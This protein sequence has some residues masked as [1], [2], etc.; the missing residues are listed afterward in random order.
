MWVSWKAEYAVAVASDAAGSLRADSKD[1]WI[2]AQRGSLRGGT[3]APRREA[4]MRKPCSPAITL[5]LALT[6]LATTAQATVYNANPGNYLAFI[7]LLQPG[8]TLSLAAGSYTGGLT[9]NDL[10]GAPG[11]PIVI[12]GPPAPPRAVFQA[13]SCCNTVSISDS[14]YVDIHNLELNGRNL[15]VDAVKAEG[16]SQWAHH[17]TLE[18]LLIRNHAANQQIVGINTKCPAWN[19]VIRNNVI[20]TAGTGIYLG[21]SDGSDEFVAGLIEGNLIADTTGYNLQIK[22][23]LVR[24]TAI[25]EPVVGHTIIRHNVFIKA[26]KAST[27]A[28]ARPNVLVGHWPLSGVGSTDVYMIYGNAFVQNPTGQGLFQGEGNVAL[29]NNVFFNNGNKQHNGIFIQPQNDVPKD[30]VVFGNTVVVKGTGISITGGAPAH[31]QQVIGNAVFAANPIV[32]PDQ[33][34][35]VTATL[36]SASSYLVS[37][38]APLGAGKNLYPRVGTLDGPPLD[39]TPFLAFDDYDRDFNWVTRAF[40]FRGG[41][42]GEGTNPGWPLQRAR[43]PLP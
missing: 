40:L 33:S 27:G 14:S 16:T 34:S 7:P 19:W 37:P 20:D 29:Y 13:R 11:A 9:L 18:N 21:D 42:E 25:G 2:L 38:F 24:N 43:K 15:A 17:I 8:D 32:A 31:Q 3:V 30:V 39:V 1:L 41:Y 5:V 4:S 26:A 36:A 6:I 10:N 23:Q 12:V 22:H 28:N 35:N